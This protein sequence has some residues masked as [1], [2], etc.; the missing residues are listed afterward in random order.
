MNIETLS[1][2]FKYLSSKITIFKLDDYILEDIYNRLGEID[3]LI[4]KNRQFNSSVKKQAVCI[5][6]S[7]I[8]GKGMKI[9]D[10][11]SRMISKNK[12]FLLIKIINLVV[13]CLMIV[14]M[15]VVF[16]IL[17]VL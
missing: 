17:S 6:E 5:T 14:I 7:S 8:Y 10:I 12:V 16:V 4:N 15:L 1:R 9:S 3:V 2:R 13:I 11:I